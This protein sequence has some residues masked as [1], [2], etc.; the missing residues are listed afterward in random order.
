MKLNVC[1]AVYVVL[2]TSICSPDGNVSTVI[3]T[4]TVRV[5]LPL[6]GEKN[7]LVAVIVLVPPVTPVANPVLSMVATAVVSLL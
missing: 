3:G 5:V 7:M 4:F 2:S 1:G 6:I